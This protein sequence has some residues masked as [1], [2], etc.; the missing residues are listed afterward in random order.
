MSRLT[1]C[2]IMSILDQLKKMINSTI[3]KYVTKHFVQG[4]FREGQL[5]SSRKKIKTRRRTCLVERKLKSNFNGMAVFAESFTGVNNG[6]KN[7]A[8]ML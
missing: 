1:W 3:L 5:I 6:K 8:H 2:V 4:L 7:K